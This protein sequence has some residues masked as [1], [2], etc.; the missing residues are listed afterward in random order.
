[1]FCHSPVASISC[2]RGSDLFQVWGPHAS[3]KVRRLI[4]HHLVCKQWYCL[5]CSVVFQWQ[6]SAKY[7]C[8]VR[9]STLCS[10]FSTPRYQTWLIVLADTYLPP[11][12]VIPGD[13][14]QFEAM[15]LI[16]E[17]A[18]HVCP[19]SER[20]LDIPDSSR[21]RYSSSE[22]ATHVCPYSARLDIPGSSRPHSSSSE[23]A[24]H[25]CP[26]SDNT[27]ATTSLDEICPRSYNPVPKVTTT[28]AP[29]KSFP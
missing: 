14:R 13:T 7:F 5:E 15:L 2:K 9:N 21:P 20:S 19:Y 25:V 24:T 12:R 11:S 10:C 23:T 26:Y 18:T 4:P 28:E 29:S 22:T 6:S 27:T 17:T 16:P 1:M 8:H 3:N